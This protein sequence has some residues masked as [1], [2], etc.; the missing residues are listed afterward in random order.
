MKI[1]DSLRWKADGQTLGSGGQAVVVSVIDKEGKHSG[2][3]ALKGLSPGKPEKAYER[4]AREV[5]AIKALRH[6][7]VVRIIDHSEKADPFQFYVMEYIEGAKPLKKFITSKENPFHGD[8]LR[9]LRF[10]IQLASAIHAWEEAKI[11][12][13]DLSP[14]NILILP[15]GDIKVIDFGVCQIEDAETITLVDEGVGSQNYMAPECEA[16]AAGEVKSTADL[17]SAGKLLWSA[18][19]SQMAFSREKPAFATKSLREVFPERPFT[20][21]LHHIFEKTIRHESKD[22]V[23]NAEAAIALARRVE[24]LILGG[25]TPIE[26]LDAQCPMCGWGRMSGFDGSHMVF[27]NPNPAGIAALRCDYCG[28]CFAIDKRIDKATLDKRNNLT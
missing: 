3:Y 2:R 7:N 22:R 28:F 23:K 27:G 1:P 21:H 16:G 4:F 12:H 11:V 18:I 17:Y 15:N 14:A 24:F 26:L 13:R 6:P 10:F 8:A 20:W 9:S 5:E 25:Y 19:T